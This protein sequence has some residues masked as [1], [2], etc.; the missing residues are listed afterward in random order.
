MEP[1]PYSKVSSN[2]KTP[3]LTAA[4]LYDILTLLAAK[5]EDSTKTF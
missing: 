5:T 1:N 3:H 2:V 4:L